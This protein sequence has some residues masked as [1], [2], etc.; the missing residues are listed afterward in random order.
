[1]QTVC[2]ASREQ[3]YICVVCYYLLVIY[4]ISIFIFSVLF[5]LRMGGLKGYLSS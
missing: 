5:S 4:I 3:P 1:M 2:V